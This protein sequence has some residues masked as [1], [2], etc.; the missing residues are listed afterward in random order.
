MNLRSK[1]LS[2][3]ALV[4]FSATFYSPAIQAEEKLKTAA[5]PT[6]ERALGDVTL[7]SEIEVLSEVFDFITSE[8]PQSFVEG[9]NKGFVSV[10]SAFPVG[11]S[12]VSCPLCKGGKRGSS[13]IT[14]KQKQELRK[15]AMMN[16]GR[17]MMLYAEMGITKD[18]RNKM[19]AAAKAHCDSVK[20]KVKAIG[21]SIRALDAATVADAD[22]ATIKKAVDQIGVSVSAAIVELLDALTD[23]KKVL[24]KEQRAALDRTM[25][26][27]VKSFEEF[28]TKNGMTPIEMAIKSRHGKK[29]GCPLASAIKSCKKRNARLKYKGHS[30]KHRL[31][32]KMIAGNLGR[33]LILYSELDITTEQRKGIKASLVK[34]RGDIKSDLGSLKTNCQALVKTTILG[35]NDKA[36]KMAAD[37]MGN[38]VAELALEITKT[39]QDVRKVL[40]DGQKKQIQS[41][42]ADI[43]KS[44]KQFKVKIKALK[45]PK[46]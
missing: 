34:H 31:F 22:D 33:L 1:W 42:C 21:K 11:T 16:G 19:K 7:G 5:A 44:V 23:A 6:V 13:S 45:A 4:A 43:K 36:R 20:V 35:Q 29:G 15:F 46:A 41:T 8:N 17:L 27:V 9:K 32:K 24:S 40:T 12:A 10:K 14:G 38:A 30:E 28:K 26:M 2:T 37:N 39:R 18:Q 3:L 25:G